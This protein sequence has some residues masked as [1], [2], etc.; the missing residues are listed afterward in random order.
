M[1]RSL[2]L[3]LALK[4]SMKAPPPLPAR[5]NTAPSTT[6]QVPMVRHGCLALAMAMPR[7]ILSMILPFDGWGWLRPSTRIAMRP[8]SPSPAGVGCSLMARKLGADLVSGHH[9]MW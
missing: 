9:H 3:P 8:F 7:V 4:A 5:A 6:T 2:W 1:A